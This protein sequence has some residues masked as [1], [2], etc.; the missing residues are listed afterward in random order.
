MLKFS[1]KLTLK[2]LQN[3]GTFQEHCSPILVQKFGGVLLEISGHWASNCGTI[4]G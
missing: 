2:V 4:W 1:T 3:C